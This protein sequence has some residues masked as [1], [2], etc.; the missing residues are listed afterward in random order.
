MSF[1]LELFTSVHIDTAS[2]C[3]ISNLECSKTVDLY[4]TLFFQSLNYK[5]EHSFC[6]SL[7]L[8]TGDVGLFCKQGT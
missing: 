8:V 2:A 5:V 7:G 1:Y 6:K 4:N 3:N